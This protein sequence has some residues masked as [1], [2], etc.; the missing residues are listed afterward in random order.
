MHHRVQV[1]KTSRQSRPV[2]SN[3]VESLRFC[4]RSSRASAGLGGGRALGASR[5]GDRRRTTGGSDTMALPQRAFFTVQE[6]AIRW[7]C[8]L[9]DIAGWAV[10]GTFEIVTAINR[11]SKAPM[12]WQISSLSRR[13]TS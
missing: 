5:K 9:D 4:D 12:S 3:D 6:T 10:T 8:S 13:P 2:R 7:G 1:V 11:S